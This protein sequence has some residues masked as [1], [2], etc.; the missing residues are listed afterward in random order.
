M[1]KLWRRILLSLIMIAAAFTGLVRLAFA[2]EGNRFLVSYGGTA[3]YQL[4]LWVNKELGFSK[5]HGV[6]LGNRFDPGGLAEYSGLTR[7]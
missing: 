5:K 3:G 2:V 1:T 6:D 4:P 7:R